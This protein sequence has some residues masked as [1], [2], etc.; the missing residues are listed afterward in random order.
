[1]EFFDEYTESF[2]TFLKLLLLLD[3]PRFL[4]S[5]FMI[6]L[7]VRFLPEKFSIAELMNSYYAWIELF[8]V[9]TLVILIT[10][11]VIWCR[12]ELKSL[13]IKNKAIK[14]LYFLSNYE[15]DILKTAYD[16]GTTSIFSSLDSPGVTALHKKNII[17]YAGEFNPL[18]QTYIIPIYIWKEIIK[19]HNKILS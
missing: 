4:F 16:N 1:M 9:V 19:N 12:K 14:S 17:D 18:K 13:S 3:R 11:F 7:I 6:C 8:I 5:V 15:K 10:H 2:L